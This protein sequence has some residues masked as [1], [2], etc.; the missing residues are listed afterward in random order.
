LTESQFIEQNKKQW[1]DLEILLERETRDADKLHKLFVKVSSDLSYARTFYPNRSVRL[2]LNNLTQRVLDS[3]RTTEDKFSFKKILHFFQHTLPVEIYHSRKA[4]YISFSV[5]VIALLIGIISSANNPEFPSVILGQDY[6]D[7]T[8]ENINSGDPMAVYKDK[9]KT[10]MFLHITTNNIRVSFLAFVL[11]LMGS[12][13]T[14]I[15]LLSNGIMVGAFQYYFYSKGLF[16]TSFLTIWCHGTIEISAIIIAGA[17]GI[18]LGNGLLFP[19]TFK[20]TTSL[21]ISAMRALRILLGTVPLFIIA[22]LLES[23]VTRLT[24]LPMIVKIAIIFFSFL[25][26]LIMFV[27]YPIYYRRA[28]SV[29]FHRFDIVPNHEEELEVNKNIFKNLGEILSD[30][31]YEFR[32]YFGKNMSLILFPS[33]VVITV[34][35]WFYMNSNYDFDDM[36][37]YNVSFFSLKHGNIPFLFTV[38][39][40]GS[41]S[42]SLIGFVMTGVPAT[43]MSILKFIKQHFLICVFAFFLIYLPF[44]LDNNYYLLLYLIIPPHFG[45]TLIERSIN[46]AKWEQMSTMELYSNAIKNWPK[47]IIM[48]LIIS[49]V[50]YSA[51]ALINS[52]LVSFLTDFIKWHDIFESYSAESIYV[53]HLLSWVF[54][55]LLAPIFYYLISN[56]VHS[57]NCQETALD[58]Q[59]KLK[60]FGKVSTVFE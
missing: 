9:D 34:F 7:M 1:R 31:L 54:F 38:W 29:R 17:A 10:S 36:G 27:I 13:G 46:P 35:L 6:I 20:R 19:R 4:F 60:S 58:L 39:L 14:I 18:V 25:L 50:I 47:Y 55:C 5:F 49:V 33:L 21:Q 57:T 30:S 32:K 22:G 43:L 59:I 44:A 11:G 26:I 15:V 40:L 41:I 52:T 2:Y 16:L 37:G 8:E 24:D 12:I 51:W 53:L 3:M 48:Y 56:Q 28:H 23:F 42:L 45:I